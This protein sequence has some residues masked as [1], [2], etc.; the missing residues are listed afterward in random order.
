MPLRS[1]HLNVTFT[2]NK[3][4]AKGVFRVVTKC[5][6]HIRLLNMLTYEKF[7][8]NRKIELH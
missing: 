8:K 2:F 1:N 3:D 5:F 6:F 4:R 7:E